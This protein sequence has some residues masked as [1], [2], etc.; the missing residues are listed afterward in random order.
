MDEAAPPPPTKKSLLARMRGF[1]VIMLFVLAAVIFI[2]RNFFTIQVKGRSMLTTFHEGERL[3]AT[4]AYWLVGPI[5]RNDVIVIKGT[6]PG[7]FWIKRVNRLG[8]ETVDFLNIPSNYDFEN[9][10]YTVPTGTLY[11]LGDNLVE[12]EDSRTFG[13]VPLDRVVGKVV[14]QR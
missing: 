9:G 5:K 1:G 12:S 3:L 7:E 8:G 6:T 14:P 10:Q 2:Y 4:R 11:V 13:P